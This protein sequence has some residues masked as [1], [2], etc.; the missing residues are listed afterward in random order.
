MTTFQ[1]RDEAGRLLAEKLKEYKGTNSIVL[2]IPRGGVPIGYLIAK[3]LQLP[4]DIVISKKICHPST[5]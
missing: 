2:A 5:P 4:L 1:N 3:E